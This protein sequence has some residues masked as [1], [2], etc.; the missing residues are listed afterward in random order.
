MWH[1]GGK[2]RL[3][4]RLWSFK[5]RAASAEIFSIAGVRSASGL[6]TFLVRGC[7]TP[8][9]RSVRPHLYRV[10]PGRSPVPWTERI[11]IRDLPKR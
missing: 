8:L 10:H 11:E 9:V 2:P 4:Q 7:S 1:W 5:T 3:W 6:G